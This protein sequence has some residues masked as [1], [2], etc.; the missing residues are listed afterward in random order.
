MSRVLTALEVLGEE[1]ITGGS[2]RVSGSSIQWL[3]N[4]GSLVYVDFQRPLIDV[5]T[6]GGSASATVRARSGGRGF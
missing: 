6:S 1:T 3:G 5:L 4:D 2:L